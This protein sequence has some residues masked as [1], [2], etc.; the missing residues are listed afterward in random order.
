MQFETDRGQQLGK[1]LELACVVGGKDEALGH[2]V[3]GVRGEGAIL[4]L[5]PGSLPRA[6]H[7]AALNRRQAENQ[8]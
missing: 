3:Y 7:H 8:G 5:A 2:G 4:A 1:F 6:A